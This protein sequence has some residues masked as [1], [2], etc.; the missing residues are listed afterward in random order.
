MKSVS[1]HREKCVS[2][3]QRTP[4]ASRALGCATLLAVMLNAQTAPTF[5]IGPK[6]PGVR[7]GDAGAGGA[8]PGL[9]LDRFGITKATFM[10]VDS[11]LGTVPNE[12][13][14][15][16]GPS[17]NMNSCAGCHAFPAVGGTSPAANP[18]VAVASLHGADNS[19]PSFID[20]DGPIREA[21]FKKNADGSP[22]GGVHDLF[23]IKGRS[24]AGGCQIP[25]T[26]F[27]SQLDRNNVIFR[28]PTPTFGAGLIE[29]VEDV[30]ILANKNSNL[31]PKGA[32]G[33]SGRENRSGNDGTITRF[34]WKAQNKSLLIFAGEAYHVEQGVTNEAFPNPRETAPG[35]DAPGLGHPEDHT[36]LATGNSGDVEQFA[37]FMRM[38]A[39][40]TPVTS[41][42]NGSATPSSIQRGHDF[43]V[44]IGCVY[45]HTETLKTGPSSIAALSNTDARLFSDLLVHNMGSGLA[46]GVSQGAAGPDEFRTAPL[47]GLG[48]RIFFLHDGRTSDLVRAIKEHSSP[49]SEANTSVDFFNRLNDPNAQD[50]LNFLRSL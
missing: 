38:L 16:L 11:V 31:G 10:E 27:R 6:D 40:P 9:N 24:D 50:V 33:I 42:G 34:G 47:W 37:L 14:K 49:G 23:T 7:G 45:C 12:G 15:G 36:D 5:N 19:I 26:D 8:Y 28:I 35:C 43:F 25:Q 17:F 22:D 44:Q 20:I 3:Q 13:G 48:K 32:F 21:R 1:L 46:D 29:A 18:Q 39:P 2:K 41:Y 30:T 4:A